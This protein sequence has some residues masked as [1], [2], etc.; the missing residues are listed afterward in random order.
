M[1]LL[2][3]LL[4]KAARAVTPQA[5]RPENLLARAIESRTQQKVFEGPFQGMKY[6]SSSVG[7]VYYPKILG[8]YEKELRGVVDAILAVKPDRLIDIGTA[9]GYYAV[10]F[11]SRLPECHIVGFET[12]AEGRLLLDS[13]A[14]M[15]DVSSRL[16]MH[17]TCE[18]AE[19][20]RAM[21]CDGKVVVIC[22]VEGYERVLLDPS[23]VPSLSRSWVL[24]ELHEFASPGVAELLSQ[25][26][27]NTHRIDR[28]WQTN[29]TKADYPFDI[30]LTRFLPDAYA[31]YRVQEF[32]PEKMS[33]FW[34]EPRHLS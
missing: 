26:F 20:Q 8:Q 33:W 11:A 22:D 13:M 18:P 5:I 24:V 28:I 14:Q 2:K 3:K 25:R 29:R 21:E 16:E 9:E 17:G 15:N 30:W 19:L 23:I 31:S 32:R 4:Q 10:G 27:R 34:M 6:C 1:M 12:S 7:S